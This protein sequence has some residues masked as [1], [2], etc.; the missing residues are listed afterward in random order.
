MP[1][2]RMNYFSLYWFAIV[3]RYRQCF[4]SIRDRSSDSRAMVLKRVCDLHLFLVW[5]SFLKC[6]NDTC[7]LR[8]TEIMN[9]KKN[10]SIFLRI[11][12]AIIYLWFWLIRDYKTTSCPSKL[13][14]IIF[15]MGFIIKEAD[16]RFHCTR[17]CAYW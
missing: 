6:Q 14:I 17:F 11:G 8:W 10:R 15:L 7:A 9:W 16:L 13:V 2:V 4:F 1:Y 3:S 5:K 12:D